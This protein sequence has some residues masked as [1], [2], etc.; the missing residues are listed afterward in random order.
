M[1]CSIAVCGYIFIVWFLVILLYWWEVQFYNDTCIHTCTFSKQHNN[2][3]LKSAEKG[4]KS[5]KLQAK[6]QISTFLKSKKCLSKVFFRQDGW[7]DD[8]ERV[9]LEKLIMSSATQ[10]KKTTF[11]C[12]R[13]NDFKLYIFFW[14]ITFLIA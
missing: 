3:L 5:V 9:N 14:S 8:V 12:A 1:I 2:N 13:F 4:L 7:A 10:M 6:H 11:T